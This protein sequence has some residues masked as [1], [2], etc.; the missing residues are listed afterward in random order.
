L[1]KKK[2]SYKK[3]WIMKKKDWITPRISIY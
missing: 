2:G 1:D 3:N